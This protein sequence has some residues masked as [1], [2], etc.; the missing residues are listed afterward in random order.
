MEQSKK[1]KLNVQRFDAIYGKELPKNH[2]IKKYFV[3]NH[4]LTD[5]QIGC[6]LSHIKIWE[7]AVKNNYKNILVFEDDATIPHDF[8]DKFNKA[9]NELPKIG[10]FY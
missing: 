6:A 9:Y 3:D 7:D 10:I 4:N 1:A 2:Y 5:G 8:W